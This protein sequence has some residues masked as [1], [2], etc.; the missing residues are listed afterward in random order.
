MELG[1]MRSL[2][3]CVIVTVLLTVLCGCVGYRLGSTLPPGI[4][5]IYVPTFKNESGEPQV[6]SETSRAA[7]AAHGSGRSAPIW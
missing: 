4:R 2:L 6:E 5:T 7:P 1:R 3:R